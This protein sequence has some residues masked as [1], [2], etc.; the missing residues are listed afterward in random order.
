VSSIWVGDE[1]EVGL[2]IRG[3]FLIGWRTLR[4]QLRS[5]RGGSAQAAI[6]CRTL[7]TNSR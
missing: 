3:H 2:I 7:R 4:S 5:L 1:V 6:C